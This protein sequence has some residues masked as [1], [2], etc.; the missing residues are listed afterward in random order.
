MLSSG[1]KV[2]M[3]EGFTRFIHFNMHLSTTLESLTFVSQAFLS[4]AK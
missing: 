2:E 4:F 3:E 1:F